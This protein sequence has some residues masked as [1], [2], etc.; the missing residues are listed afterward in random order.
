[1]STF[2]SLYKQAEKQNTGICSCHT[3]EQ[4]L[5][6]FSLSYSPA[7]I[8]HSF[9]LDNMCVGHHATFPQLPSYPT[10]TRS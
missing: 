6:Y 1:M 2:K 3:L 9:P 5:R 7:L 4:A 8:S 10:L